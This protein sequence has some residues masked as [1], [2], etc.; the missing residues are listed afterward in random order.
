MKR[1][2]ATVF[3][4][5]A[6][7]CGGSTGTVSVELVADPNSDI[8]S[9]IERV[10]LTL[11]NPPA[12]AEAVRGPDGQLVLDLEVIAA[13]GAGNLTVA[14][15][16][17]SGDR[18]AVGFSAP[19]PIEAIDGVLTLYLAP[20]L[21]I[22]AAPVALDPPRSEIAAA[23]LQF[24]T[25]F[26]GGRD[27]AGTVR[28][29]MVIYNVY[30]HDFQAGLDLPTA[31]TEATMVAGIRGLVYVFG[32]ID[33]NGNLLSDLVGFDTN[34]GP[35]GFYGQL[36]SP[37]S[38]ARGASQG[39]LVGNERFVVLGDPAVLIDGFIGAGELAD[40]V[41]LEGAVASTAVDG[42]NFA[43]VMG[44]SGAARVVD[45]AV[46]DLTPPVA[47]LRERH[48]VTALPDGD[49]IAI[50]GRDAATSTL[51]ASAVRYDPVS[52]A[53][54]VI[55]DVL[56]TPRNSPAVAAVD[57]YLIVAGGTDQA[58]E[59]I[60]DVEVF[61]AASLAPVAVL[62]LL[63]PRRNAIATPLANGQILIAGG[64]DAAG[65]PVGVLELFTPDA[66]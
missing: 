45:T 13:G 25:I 5:L 63:V 44:A 1:R 46:V 48:A 43:L 23:V 61:D 37:A 64:R 32:G 36:P 49:V 26:A 39:A 21:S 15:F 58:G 24:G 7:S 65:D 2:L 55:D 66:R 40:G 22:G 41:A 53:F 3:A 57:R 6:I 60:G 62:S 12:V 17:A 54:A 38:L 31:R 20:P 9:Q 52:G 4:G 16:D 47:A 51:L 8:L 30:D 34:V 11:D 50:G 35:A 10:Q 18:I 56:A 42:L 14:A 27:G 33:A 29:E 28:A 59:P 19:L